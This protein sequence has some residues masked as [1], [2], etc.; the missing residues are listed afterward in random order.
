MG[1]RQ[2]R[3]Y[4][5]IEKR[6]DNLLEVYDNVEENSEDAKAILESIEN[7]LDKMNENTI[8]IR[9]KDDSRV[10]R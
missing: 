3:T 2:E 6:I 9:T 7:L 1:N 4:M 5:D 10:N 8:T